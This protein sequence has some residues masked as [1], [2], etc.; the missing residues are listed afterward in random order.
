MK[1]R[2]AYTQI[3]REKLKILKEYLTEEFGSKTARKAISQITKS[4]RSLQDFPYKGVDLS[5]IYEVETEFR[6]IYV[7]HNYLFYYI[8]DDCIVIAEIFSEKEDFM[9]QLFGIESVTP[10]SEKYWGE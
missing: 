5:A 9:Y 10:E 4:A 2:L 8:E 3:V 6:Y 1:Y 7:S